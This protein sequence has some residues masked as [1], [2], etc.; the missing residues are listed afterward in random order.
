M[1]SANTKR[2]TSIDSLRGAVMALM[3]VDHVR[4]FFYLH[5]QAPAGIKEEID[6]A[7][8]WLLPGMIDDQVHFCE[9]ALIPD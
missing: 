5:L 4:E 8:Q 6:A 7:G 9:P 2:L 3:L 1:T